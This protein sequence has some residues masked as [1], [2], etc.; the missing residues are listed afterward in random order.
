[1]TS[2]ADRSRW[3]PFPLARSRRRDPLVRS[4]GRG[5]NRALTFGVNWAGMEPDPPKFKVCG[6]PVSPCVEAMLCY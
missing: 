3:R 5:S 2:T 1:M 4:G 6:S